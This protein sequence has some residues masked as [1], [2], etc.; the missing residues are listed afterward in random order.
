MFNELMTLTSKQKEALL[1]KNGTETQMALP[2]VAIPVEIEIASTLQAALRQL[3]VSTTL[4][5]T[6]YRIQ[7]AT[8]SFLP[9][10]AALKFSTCLL[11]AFISYQSHRLVAPS[12]LPIFY[13]LW[14][15]LRRS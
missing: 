6:C 8:I 13:G 15:M 1:K 12:S 7:I 10:W 14:D 5:Y 3:A 2:S 4:L 9:G 11:S